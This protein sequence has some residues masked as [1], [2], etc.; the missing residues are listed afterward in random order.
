[1]EDKLKNLEYSLILE[2]EY[3]SA[4][5]IYKIAEP[6]IKKQ[7]GSRRELPEEIQKNMQRRVTKELETRNIRDNE[8]VNSLDHIKSLLALID[9][10]SAACAYC[11]TQIKTKQDLPLDRVD[12]Y[13]G[14]VLG[15][16][17]FACKKCNFQ[18]GSSSLVDFLKTVENIYK[19]LGPASNAIESVHQ[20][21]DVMKEYVLED[22]RRSK[23]NQSMPFGKERP[24]ER[25]VRQ[26]TPLRKARGET[27]A[28]AD[29]YAEI[30]VDLLLLNDFN[31][32]ETAK[33][34]RDHSTTGKHGWDIESFKSYLRG[35]TRENSFAARIQRRELLPDLDEN[36]RQDFVEKFNTARGYKG[37]EFWESLETRKR[38]WSKKSNQN[39]PP[40]EEDADRP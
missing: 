22:I 17:V 25:S 11:G 7:A 19:H 36:K 38:D 34:L 21:R 10:G 12:N 14:Y 9:V 6:E 1:M 18:K 40:N 15:N 39:I 5:I 23:E 30:I 33:D 24:R 29:E 4:N 28:T 16:V 27:P 35:S 32:A 26:T 3:R 13:R 31:I 20:V 8:V 2:G 37:K